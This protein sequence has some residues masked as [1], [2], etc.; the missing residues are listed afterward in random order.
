MANREKIKPVTNV[1]LIFEYEAGKQGVE[2]TSR[3]HDGVEYMYMVIHNGQHSILFLPVDG[4]TAVRRLNPREGDSISLLK[5]S[6][7]REIYWEATLANQQAP[8]PATR[9]TESR[10]RG[11]YP[12]QQTTYAQPVTQTATARA[13]PPP[14]APAHTPVADGHPLEQ[15]MTNCVICAGRALAR[16]REVL[17][18][19]GVNVPEWLSDDFRSAAISMWI[20]RTKG[21]R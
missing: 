5:R 21:G 16:G 3:F 20:E 7:N 4:H 6:E 19:E 18:A 17:L 9:T 8:L 14:A 10:L 12:A 2:T 15:L 11:N 1:P 13:L